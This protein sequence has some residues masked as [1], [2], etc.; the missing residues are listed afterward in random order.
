MIE[1][2]KQVDKR[3]KSVAGGRTVAEKPH[4]LLFRDGKTCKALT[5]S[6]PTPNLGPTRRTRFGHP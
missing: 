4:L 5:A 3:D 2:R 6:E 1:G